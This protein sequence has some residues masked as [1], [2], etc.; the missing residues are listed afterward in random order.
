MT[1]QAFREKYMNRHVEMSPA[2]A[3]LKERHFMNMSGGNPGH[4]QSDKAFWVQ[5]HQL[6]RACYKS[7]ANAFPACAAIAASYRR[8]AASHMASLAHPLA[9]AQD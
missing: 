1:A 2:N 4:N 5:P 8:P 3:G 9:E 7:I 6:L